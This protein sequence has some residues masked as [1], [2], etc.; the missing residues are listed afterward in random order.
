MQLDTAATKTI[1]EVDAEL[2][3]KCKKQPREPVLIWQGF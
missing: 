1:C 2:E 3:K